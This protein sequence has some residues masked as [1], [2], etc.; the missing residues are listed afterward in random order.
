MRKLASIR[1]VRE[2]KPIEN[3]DMIELAI[4][5]GWQVVVKKNELNAG[6]LAVYFEIDS[7]L[8]IRDE[9]EFLRKSSY[10]K[11]PDSEGFRLKTIKLRG[12][13]SQG[14]LLP[15]STFPELAEACLGDP[16]FGSGIGTDV[17]D[18]LGVT[19]YEAPIPACLAGEVK[20]MFPG[21]VKKTD[22]E[23]IQNLVDWFGL[24]KDLEFEAS[25]KID[26]SS[27]TVYHNNGDVGVC[28]RNLDLKE[29]DTNTFWRVTR[30]L[31]I[32][33]AL[34]WFYN[35][36]SRNIAIQGEC[37]GEGINKNRLGLKGHNL[38]VFNVFDIDRHRYLTPGERAE[39]LSDLKDAGF[40]FEQVPIVCS[41]IKVFTDFPTMDEML[42]TAQGKS[43]LNPD[44]EREG[45]VY[46]SCDLI[47]V[48][49]ISF[50]AIN[51]KYLLKE[52]D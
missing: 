34:E 45:L 47:G 25:E 17:T 52:K 6:D 27:M 21:F 2:I 48:D 50:K 3:A 10:R 31:K 13:V 29:S 28:S 5:D 44:R 22:E 38:Y 36:N 32:I 23:R 33:D 19:K 11:L 30:K 39:V 14:L 20:G 26:G 46:K 1:E 12:Q 42:E 4:V 41:P 35:E 37:A 8:P 9:F 18:L 43:M 15:I 7:F 51:N 40:V 49:I 24:Y 16:S